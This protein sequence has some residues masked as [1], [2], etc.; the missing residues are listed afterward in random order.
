MN[1]KC[2]IFDMDGTLLDS[3]HMWHSLSSDFLI[4]NGIEVDEELFDRLA[5]MRLEQSAQYFIDTYE[6][7]SKL[8]VREILDYW[9]RKIENEYRTN[10]KIK[11]NADKFVSKIRSLGVKTAIAS[12]TD[13][14]LIK[15]A[16]DKQ[17]MLSQFDYITC[18]REVGYNKK[19][20]NIYIAC[21]E[22]LGF[23]IC[24]CAVFED[25]LYAAKTARNAN[26][27][28]I[29]VYDKYTSGDLDEF[30]AICDRVIF[31]WDELTNEL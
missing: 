10:I 3:M 29:G 4:E 14:P 2:A 30:R 21:A 27:Y 25:S 26:F 24:D 9:W 23:D 22:K 16:M 15:I 1:Y 28:T 20:P 7:F 13:T 8:T 5:H 6:Q 12:V 11:A 17:N 19:Q 18:T 31:S